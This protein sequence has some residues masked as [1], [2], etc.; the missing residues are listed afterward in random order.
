[1][2]RKKFKKYGFK[3]EVVAD[4]KGAGFD[5]TDSSGEVIA[6]EWEE[7]GTFSDSMKSARDY[8]EMEHSR[9]ATH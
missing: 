7:G 2:Q 4:D 3:F 1:M 9:C 6:S 5:M 8:A